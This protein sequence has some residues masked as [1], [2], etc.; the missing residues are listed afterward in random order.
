MSDIEMLLNADDRFVLS[1]IA[2]LAV[3]GGMGR[4]VLNIIEILKTDNPTDASACLLEAVYLDS[5]GYPEAAI[6]TLEEHNVFEAVN[7]REDAMS[8]HLHLLGK[9]GRVSQARKLGEVYLANGGFQKE[10]ARHMVV[11]TLENLTRSGAS[12]SRN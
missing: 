7:A 2:L 12:C 10:S 9:L 1:N 4:E 11:A 6:E 8:F 5:T 3:V